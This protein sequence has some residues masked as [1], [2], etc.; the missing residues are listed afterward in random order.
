AEECRTLSPVGQESGPME[1]N[2][3]HPYRR[4][5]SEGAISEVQTFS[6]LR[7]AGLAGKLTKTDGMEEQSSWTQLSTDVETTSVM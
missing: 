1:N 3:Y 5:C 6:C 7:R 2:H 4:Q